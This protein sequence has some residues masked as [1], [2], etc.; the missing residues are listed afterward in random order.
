MTRDRSVNPLNTVLAGALVLAAALCLSPALRAEKPKEE[1]AGPFKVR[2]AVDLRYGSDE[3]QV[4]DVF[5]PEGPANCPVVFFV[6]GGA[7][8]FGDKNLFGLYRAVG[9]NLASQG[10][11]AVL[12]N[13]RLT[14][15][16][17]HPEHLNDVARAFA[18]TRSNIA[19]HGG[20]PNCIFLAGHS[21]GGHLVALLATHDD[22]WN[23][24]LAGLKSSDRT[25]VRGVI[26]VSGVYRIPASNETGAMIAE[27]LNN[28]RTSGAGALPPP[29]LP[30]L[31][32]GTDFN[33]FKMVFGDDAA[34]RADASPIRHLSKNQKLPP[35]LLLTAERDLP[36]L[37]E[38]AREFTKT[39]QDTG[40]PAEYT[41]IAGCNHNIIL[42]NLHKQDDPT[43]KAIMSFLDSHCTRPKPAK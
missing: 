6:H 40:H 16:V 21:A 23:K 2:Q 39:L 42:F 38:M 12:I 4:L 29:R 14:P 37:P 9:R 20:D 13:Y 7:W 22:V 43:S 30:R 24:S 15:T 19:K 10:C 17:K 33:L 41:R 8:M 3:R 11:V 26:G 32:K 31:G 35:F 36:L 34:V 1:L 28:F 5:R 25:A 18:W 27:L